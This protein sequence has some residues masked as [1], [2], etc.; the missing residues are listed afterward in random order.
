MLSLF[1]NLFLS[2]VGKI[3]ICPFPHLKC[4]GEP[5]GY[6]HKLLSNLL[7]YIVH[8]HG[9]YFSQLSR[10]NFRCHGEFEMA[11]FYCACI[12]NLI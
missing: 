10:T 8:M 2:S 7:P 3:N 9:I 12:Q 11:G 5:D 6:S 1:V 4:I